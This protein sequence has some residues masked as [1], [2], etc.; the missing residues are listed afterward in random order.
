MIFKRALLIIPNAANRPFST[1]QSL[2]RFR[3]HLRPPK[4]I[5]SAENKILSNQ[6]KFYGKVAVGFGII[7]ISTAYIYPE[8]FKKN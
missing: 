4:N 8:L 7:G 5:F 6:K 2:R 1:I 3:G